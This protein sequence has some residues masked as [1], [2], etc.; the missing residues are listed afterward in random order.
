M[1]PTLRLAQGRYQVGEPGET[2]APRGER[3]CL[4]VDPAATCR[5]G[6]AFYVSLQKHPL[7]SHPA[8]LAILPFTSTPPPPPLSP[9]S[10]PGKEGGK[11]RRQGRREG[12]EK[13]KKR[14]QGVLK[15][16]KSSCLG[17]PNTYLSRQWAAV[18]THSGDIRV[19]PQKCCL[20]LE[21]KCARIL[22]KSDDLILQKVRKWCLLGFEV[23]NVPKGRGGSKDSR[24]FELPAVSGSSGGHPT[25]RGVGWGGAGAQARP[26]HRGAKRHGTNRRP[27]GPGLQPT[28][29]SSVSFRGDLCKAWPVIL[30]GAKWDPE[31]LV[32]QGHLLMLFEKVRFG[33]GET[34]PKSFML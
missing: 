20:E 9:A 27:F 18:S 24:S 30:Q 16:R 23:I 4:A 26:V 25:T 13:M 1:K 34:S 3:L 14:R 29:V 6:S 10:P 2:N 33:A 19:P 22:V 11:G 21:G 15:T 17:S 5:T 32:I 28:E 8:A 12:R 7:L 31:W